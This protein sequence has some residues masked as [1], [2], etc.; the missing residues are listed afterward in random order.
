M[1]PA[2]EFGKARGIGSGVAVGVG[3]GSLLGRHKLATT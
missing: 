1:E 3:I 2:R